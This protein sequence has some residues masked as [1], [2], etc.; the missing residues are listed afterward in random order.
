MHWSSDSEV[1]TLRFP[2]ALTTERTMLISYLLYGIFIKDLTLRLNKSNN[3]LG[4]NLKKLFTS[5]SCTHEPAIH[6]SDTSQR[7]SFWQLSIYHNIYVYKDVQQVIHRLYM[8][9]M[10][11]CRVIRNSQSERVYY[12]NKI[13]RYFNHISG[14]SN[15][16]FLSNNCSKEQIY[17]LEISC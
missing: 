17:G 7:I 12:C 2:R 1:N 9:C 10:D 15:D 4:D 8:P 16:F 14:A 6:L 3:W 5:M 11:K 13:T